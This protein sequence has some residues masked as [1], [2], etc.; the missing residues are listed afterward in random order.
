MQDKFKALLDD[1]WLAFVCPFVMMFPRNR[2]KILFGAWGG[3]QFSDNP[4]YFLRWLRG[5]DLGYEL[6][7]VGG[8]SVCRQVETEPGVR[9][10]RKGSW[11]A[12]WEVLTCGWMCCNIGIASDITTF[13][14]FGRV[15]QLNFWHGT[16]FK[17]VPS[18]SGDDIP[19]KG[20][21]FRRIYWKIMY[22]F[23]A[24]ARTQASYATFSS[25]R[26]CEIMERAS[27]WAFSVDRSIA[28]GSPRIDFL[29]AH[30]KD[31]EFVLS[32]KRKYGALLGL[33][34]DRKWYLYMPT[35]RRGLDVKFSFLTSPCL[36]AYD[37]VLEEKGAIII[38][39]QHPQVMATL[40][41]D[42][43][44]RGNVYVI[45]AK[46]ATM[47][48]DT[49]ELLLAADVLISDY[50]ACFCDFMAMNR[51]VIHWAYDYDWYIREERKMVYTLDEY[52]AGPIAKT[53][54]ELLA[55]LKMEPCG[56]LA[57]RTSKSCELVSGESGHACERF[58]RYVGVA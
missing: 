51:P 6:V 57:A 22:D 33:P 45:S 11:R 27:G 25:L 16:A 26:M 19:R 31:W 48:I 18:W 55:A 44:C 35:W 40:A 54:N 8:E 2:K 46:A 10:V 37:R 14:T 23:P 1:V 56:L 21:L 43:G 32:L 24:F 36:E 53:E 7:W 13:P 17:G 5:R 12:H 50:S 39:K 3:T 29:L 58:A 4:K 15:R 41:L 9:F 42:Q 52:A 20:G 49:Q 28:E 38:E 30:C 47:E 34:V